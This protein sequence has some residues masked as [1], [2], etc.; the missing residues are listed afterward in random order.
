MPDD[1]VAVFAQ[2]QD[3]TWGK[4][5]DNSHIGLN[6]LILSPAAG[7]EFTRIEIEGPFGSK[8]TEVGVSHK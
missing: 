6:S 4:N 7:N 2:N 8:A 1:G 5:L 3:G